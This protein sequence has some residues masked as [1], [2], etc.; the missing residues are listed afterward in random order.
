MLP[1]GKPLTR[2]LTSLLLALILLM[3]LVSSSQPSSICSCSPLKDTWSCWP[4]VWP[5]SGHRQCSTHSWVCTTAMTLTLASQLDSWKGTSKMRP[6]FAMLSALVKPKCLTKSCMTSWLMLVPV[7]VTVLK[8]RA[9][10]PN[11]VA[12]FVTA[13][14][15]TEVSMSFGEEP[16]KTRRLL[17][18]SDGYW[19][20]HVGILNLRTPT[21]NPS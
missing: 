12:T 18:C 1:S 14:G 2:W 5:P 3:A 9:T 16:A 11:A 21:A 13:L 10:V 20:Q 15:V 17:A 7:T 19:W 6:C 8:T 4:L